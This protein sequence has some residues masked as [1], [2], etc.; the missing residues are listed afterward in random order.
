M[1]STPQVKL[2]FSKIRNK[3]SRQQLP[4]KKR[5][6][7]CKSNVPTG[8]SNTKVWALNFRNFTYSLKTEAKKKK[9]AKSR[10][11]SSNQEPDLYISV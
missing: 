9:N 10:T 6:Q 11:N 1:S 8:Q 5:A 7:H 4:H 2:D 3:L